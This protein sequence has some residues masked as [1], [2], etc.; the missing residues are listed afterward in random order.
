VLR[1]EEFEAAFGQS[2]AT[3]FE[4]ELQQLDPFVADDLIERADDGSIVVLPLGRLLVRN[5]AMTFDAYLADQRKG[6]K[7]MFSKTV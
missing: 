3:R 1:A 4:S 7:P 5:V 2:F 6:D